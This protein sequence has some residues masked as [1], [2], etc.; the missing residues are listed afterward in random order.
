MKPIWYIAREKFGPGSPKG[1]A[2]YKA[3]ARLPQLIE[4]V[5][6][7]NILCP[8]GTGELIPEDWE[9][10]VQQNFKIDFFIHLDYLLGRVGNRSAM[11]ILAVIEEPGP[12]DMK[13]FHDERFAFKGFDLVERPESDVSALVNCGGFDLAFLPEDLNPYGLIWDYE[14]A[15]DVQQRL[16]THYPEEHH[17]HCALW[18]IWRMER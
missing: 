7:D 16:V 12:A 2:E 13:S 8:N 17:A 14:A 4:V 3:W 9:H 5:S 15:R 6:L 11:N 18:A 10:N 1:W